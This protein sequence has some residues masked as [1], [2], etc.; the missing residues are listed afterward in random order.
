MCCVFALDHVYS[1]LSLVILI[2]SRLYLHIAI[3]EYYRTTLR[4]TDHR[5]TD[6]RTTAHRTAP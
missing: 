5:T 3:C 4:T 1:V 2:D 6:C